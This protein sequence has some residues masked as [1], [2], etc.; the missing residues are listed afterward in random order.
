MLII[1]LEMLLLVRFSVVFRL[2]I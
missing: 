1:V 2:G